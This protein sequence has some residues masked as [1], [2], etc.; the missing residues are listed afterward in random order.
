MIITVRG[1]DGKTRQLDLFPPL[2]L[3]Q[4]S[5]QQPSAAAGL[6][7]DV[8]RRI[9]SF[10]ETQDRDLLAAD[11]C[12][13]SWRQAAVPLWHGRRRE[14][15]DYYHCRYRLK[16]KWRKLRGFLFS[17]RVFLHSPAT[18]NDI[19]ALK[20][21][22]RPWELP[23]VLVASLKI[24][25]GEREQPRGGGGMYL[26]ARLLSAREIQKVVQQWRKGMPENPSVLIL[27]LFAQ[28]GPRQVAMELRLEEQDIVPSGR[29]VLVSSLAPW[30]PHFRVLAATWED[31]LTLV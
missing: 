12:C 5:A 7:A 25:D 14:V 23:T 8:I 2:H 17:L 20:R 11:S 1:A 3:R 27:P 28:T 10:L 16:F 9:V 29:I 21:I 19:D 24:H 18:E 22:V 26:G 31:F 4:S 30:A 6:P 15:V 13:R